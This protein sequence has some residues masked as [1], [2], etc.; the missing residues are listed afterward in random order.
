MSK[1]PIEAIYPLSPTQ[2]G[3]LF[4]TLYDPQAGLYVEQ[5]TCMLQGDLDRL[6][7]FRAW[8][9]ALDRHPI[10]R[11]LF[12]WERRDTPLQVVRSTVALPWT[13]YDWRALTPEQQQA[14]FDALLRDDRARGFKLASA[15]LMR[16]VLLQL[17]DDSY[18]LVWS[19]HH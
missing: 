12:R 15:P 7:F 4:H 1:Q 18:R 11:T 9:A 6:A 19:H 13:L 5:L 17:A 2:Q 3:I 16:L 8:Q 14:Q 10:L